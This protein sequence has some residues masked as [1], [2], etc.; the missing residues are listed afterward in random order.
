[1]SVASINRAQT[2][3]DDVKIHAEKT[4]RKT[5][6]LDKQYEGK[7]VKAALALEAKIYRKRET[8]K[9]KLIILNGVN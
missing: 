9:E 1:M 6:E 8:L 5:E 7:L 4:N 2:T 3:A